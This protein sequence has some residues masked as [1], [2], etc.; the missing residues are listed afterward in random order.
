MMNGLQATTA[1]KNYFGDP[2][3]SV[4][5]VVNAAQSIGSFVALPFI[6]YLSDRIGRRWTLLA[7]AITIIIASIIQAAAVDYA[8]FVV[9]RILVGVGS[10]LVV[11]PAPMLITE[12]CYPTHRGKYTSLFWTCYYFGAILAAWTTYGTQKHMNNSDWAWRA[13]SIVQAGYPLVQVIFWWFLPESPRWLIAN[14]RAGEAK[15]ILARFHTGGDEGH[16]LLAFE[17][18]EIS[19]TIE[20]EQEAKSTKWSALIATPGNRKRTL[21]AVCVGGFAQW[22]GIAVVSYY[23]TLVLDTVG[24]T[25]PDTQTLINGILQIFNFGAAVSAAFLVD[26]LGRR[27][28]FIWSG[29]GMLV[30]FIIWT[31][32]SAVFDQEGSK[33]AGIVVV[34]FIFVFF[35]HYDIAYTPLL[36]GY[37]TEIFPYSLRSKG[38]TVEL[39]TVYGS[40]IIL[41]FVNPIALDNIGWHYYI[42]FCVLLAIFFVVTFFLFPETKGYSLEEIAE[43]FDG[44]GA[45]R[46]A[47]DAAAIRASKAENDSDYLESETTHQ[48]MGGKY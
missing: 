48:E 17:M 7:G 29:A 11:Q 6:G 21:I 35:F 30:S 46:H 33:A 9:A 12:L 34:A 4:L 2:K 19:R 40:L 27:T 1:W 14:G 44:P 37:P 47:Q 25:D 10:M 23:L 38:L 41:S 45:T 28:L 39:L 3:G 8:M 32:C 31:A 42:V 16:Q 22:N 24:V 20:L 15:K 36:L 26:R 43:V 5:G 18:E 13:P